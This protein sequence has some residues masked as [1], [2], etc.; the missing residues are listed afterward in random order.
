MGSRVFGT[1][2]ARFGAA[3]Q[4]H[5]PV[6]AST[7]TLVS[8]GGGAGEGDGAAADRAGKRTG[9]SRHGPWLSAF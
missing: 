1:G 9:S 6:S 5:A 4:G 8:A 3:E 2:A 7:V